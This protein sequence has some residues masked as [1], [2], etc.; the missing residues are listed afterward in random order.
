MQQ[1]QENNESKKHK[2]KWRKCLSGPCVA[3]HKN[4]INRIFTQETQAGSQ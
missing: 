3:K 4:R 2:C 1:K